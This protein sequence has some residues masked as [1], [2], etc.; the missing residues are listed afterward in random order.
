[1]Q[2]QTLAA[3]TFTDEECMVHIFTLLSPSLAAGVLSHAASTQAA[4]AGRQSHSHWKHPNCP[5]LTISG[6]NGLDVM[7]KPSDKSQLPRLTVSGRDA[8]GPMR[9]PSDKNQLP[10]LTISGRDGLGRMR[11]PS[12]ESQLPEGRVGM[13]PGPIGVQHD[14]LL[15]S[16]GWEHHIELTLLHDIKVLRQV[17]LQ[18]EVDQA[19][20]WAAL[21]S[22]AEQRAG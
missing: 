18:V 22:R 19:L 20:R 10:R 17:A 1:M 5:R 14:R 4:I 13:V 3:H 11:L 15:A 8:L 16:I 2:H 7:Q 12:D 9:L 6:R 21:A